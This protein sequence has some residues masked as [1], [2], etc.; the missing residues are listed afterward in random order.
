MDYAGLPY[1]GQFGFIE[2][3]MH[4]SITH[5][6]APKEDALRCN[7]CHTRAEDGRLVEIT[8][9]YL[10]GRDRSALLDRLGFGLAGLMLVGAIGH[11]S[12][13]FLSRNKRN[14]EH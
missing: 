5:M 9:I 13:R 7:E 14:K 6:V 12:L 2:P 1:S 4:W 10:P 11:G 3:P 8:D